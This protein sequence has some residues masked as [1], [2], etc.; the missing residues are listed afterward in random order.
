L[1]HLLLPGGGGGG[2]DAGRLWRDGGSGG[3]GS[4]DGTRLQG[5]ATM[6]GWYGNTSQTLPGS[7]GGAGGGAEGGT[8][9]QALMANWYSILL[10]AQA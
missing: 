6:M 2:G 4:G 1:V 10:L 7:R 8:L 9:L 5:S 3:G